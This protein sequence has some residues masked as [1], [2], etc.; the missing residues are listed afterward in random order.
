MNVK[1]IIEKLQKEY[2]SKKIIKNDE[3]NPTEIVCEI[4]PTENHSECSTAIAIIDQLIAHYHKRTTEIYEVLEGELTLTING[5]E[6]LLKKGDKTTIK[7]NTVHSARGSE[8]WIK[9][10]SKPGWIFEDHILVK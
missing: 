7:P 10:Y 1:R 5:K 9:A 4:D 2:P 8:T 6:I 3:K